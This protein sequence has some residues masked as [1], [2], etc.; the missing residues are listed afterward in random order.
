MLDRIPSTGFSSARKPTAGA[1]SATNGLDQLP[2][3]AVGVEGCPDQDDE[4]GGL[5]SP[6]SSRLACPGPVIYSSDAANPESSHA[7]TA[8]F[9]ALSAI[10]TTN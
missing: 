7:Y 9:G 5:L 10:A 2:H 8:S 6:A 1:R 3:R 4:P